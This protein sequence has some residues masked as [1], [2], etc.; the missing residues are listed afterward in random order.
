MDV[1]AVEEEAV[2]FPGNDQRMPHTLVSFKETDLANS[3]VEG[4]NQ[5]KSSL[6]K[7]GQEVL[8]GHNAHN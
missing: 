6:I 2:E 4:K 5:V 1:I 8:S 3:Y 7:N